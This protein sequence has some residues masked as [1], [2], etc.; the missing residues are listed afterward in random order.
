MASPNTPLSAFLPYV[1]PKAPHCAEPYAEFQLRMAAIDFCERTRCWRHMLTVT[2]SSTNRTLVAPANTTIHE[3]EEVRHNGLLLTP[4][5]YT[6]AEPPEL[7]GVTRAG[8]PQ[9]VSQAE[10]GVVSIFPYQ[11]GTLKLSVFLKPRHGQAYGADPLDPLRD[12]FNVVPEFM[13]AQHAE[14]LAAGALARILST[15]NEPFTD[16]AAASAYAML[17]DQRASSHFSRNIRGQ[18]RAPIRTKPQW[19]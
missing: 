7:T 10:P 5:Q 2:V 1:L 15:P 18:E 8:A 12:A 16:P 13:L 17:F 11:A 3:F 14:T 4:T 19:L 6:D 9:Y